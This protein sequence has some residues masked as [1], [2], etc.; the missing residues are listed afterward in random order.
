MVRRRHKSLRTVSTLIGLLV[1]AAVT[2][3]CESLRLKAEGTEKRADWGVGI[4]F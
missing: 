1:V 4:L 2:A 3:S